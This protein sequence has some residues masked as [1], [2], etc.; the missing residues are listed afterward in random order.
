MGTGQAQGRNTGVRVKQITEESWE[1]SMEAETRE[2]LIG[3][4]TRVESPAIIPER[5][6]TA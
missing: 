3:G 1:E 5:K 4:G 2:E 6:P